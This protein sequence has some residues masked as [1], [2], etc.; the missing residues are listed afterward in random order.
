MTDIHPQSQQRDV[1]DELVQQLLTCG[2]ALNELFDVII[3]SPSFM[4]LVQ[5][6]I[7]DVLAAVMARNPAADIE[8]AATILGDVA[9]EIAEEVLAARR[10]PL[11]LE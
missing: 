10:C 6:S 7:R 3:E 2:D 1:V 11:P 5:Q 4:E 9:G 8:T